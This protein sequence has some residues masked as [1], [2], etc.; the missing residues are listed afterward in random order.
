MRYLQQGFDQL[1]FSMWPTTNYSFFFSIDSI[2]FG[3]ECEIKLIV[4]AL[5]QAM[6][7]NTIHLLIK[8]CLERKF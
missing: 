7:F 3:D 1:V 8:F 6:L 2:N 4:L 5:R